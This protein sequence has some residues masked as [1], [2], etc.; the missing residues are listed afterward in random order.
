MEV[1][2]RGV[3]TVVD[4]AEIITTSYTATGTQPLMMSGVKL[5]TLPR[6]AVFDLVA[7]RLVSAPGLPDT[8]GRA[9]GGGAGGRAGRVPGRGADGSPPRA[10]T[11]PPRNCGAA[12]PPP[13]GPR[14]SATPR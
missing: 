5:H 10:L 3:V 6:G 9:V 12:R 1:K 7:R 14:R 13:D 8:S 11:R 4:G 2:G